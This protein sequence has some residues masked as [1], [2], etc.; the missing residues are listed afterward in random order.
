MAPASS[1][2]ECSPVGQKQTLYKI[3]YFGL[4]GYMTIASLEGLIGQS[5]QSGI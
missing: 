3:A 5:G 2:Q 4:K 1:L